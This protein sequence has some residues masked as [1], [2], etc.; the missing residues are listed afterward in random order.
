MFVWPLGLMAIGYFL[1]HPLSKAFGYEVLDKSTDPV[2]VLQIEENSYFIGI[3]NK[4]YY[5]EFREM[6]AEYIVEELGEIEYES[7]GVG[8]SVS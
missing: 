2:H 3:H 7:G 8:V 5:D 6:N 4:K 1:L